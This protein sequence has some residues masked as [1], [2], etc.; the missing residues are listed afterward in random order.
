MSPRTGRPKAEV[1]R[2]L[3][4]DTRLSE[5]EMKKLDYCCESLGLKRADV[6]RKGIDKVYDELKTNEN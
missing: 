5:Q 4:V 2:N 3:K 6:I 1:V